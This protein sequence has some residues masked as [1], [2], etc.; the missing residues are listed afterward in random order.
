MLGSDKDI[1][2]LNGLITTTID[3]A[4]GFRRSAENVNNPGFRQ[5][6]SAFAE[7]RSHVATRLQQ[8]VRELGGTPEDEGSM[9]A[10][11]H[12]RWED[13]KRAISSNEDQVVIDEVERGEDHIKAKFESALSDGSLTPE[14]MVIVRQCYE[15]VREGHD[16]ARRLKQA[17]HGA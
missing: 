11:L 17:M 8:R 12:R 13:L 14:S 16:V 5:T 10:G 4:D 9:T 6:F 1:S 7:E 3:S 2:I 15:S